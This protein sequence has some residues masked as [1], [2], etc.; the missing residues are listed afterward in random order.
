MM[1]QNIWYLED[2]VEMAR[3][4][5]PPPPVATI[6]PLPAETVE[7]KENRI[8]QQRLIDEHRRKR[9]LKFEGYQDNLAIDYASAI[10]VYYRFLSPTIQIDLN[11]AIEEITPATTDIAIHYRRM[12]AHLE[13]KWGPNSEKDSEEA[14]RK[15]ALLIVD[16]R[17]ADVFLAAVFAIID[18]LA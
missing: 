7:E 17:G 3:R 10:A 8:R 14:L 11:R 15:L 2:K 13:D 16:D 6:P 18:L 12:K 4:C 5:N 1:S 9:E